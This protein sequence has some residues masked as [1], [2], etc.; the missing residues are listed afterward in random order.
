MSTPTSSHYHDSPRWALSVCNQRL[1]FDLT[2]CLPLS[3]QYGRLSQAD[4]EAIVRR[5]M[6]QAALGQQPVALRQGLTYVH[7]QRYMLP[8][9]ATVAPALAPGPGDKAGQGTQPVPT[10]RKAPRTSLTDVSV[11]GS[12]TT[13]AR[14]GRPSER[15][16]N[17]RQI[18]SRSVS[19]SSKHRAFSRGRGGNSVSAW[20]LIQL[21]SCDPIVLDVF[22]CC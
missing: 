6:E 10:R 4:R 1:R 20:R 12:F 8:G 14:V 17:E 3:S 22:V 21:L 2:H 19:S 18:G 15:Q 13:S 16:P 11:G 9:R 7:E 5:M